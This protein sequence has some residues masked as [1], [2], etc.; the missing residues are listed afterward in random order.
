MLQNFTSVIIPSR[1]TPIG[2]LQRAVASIEKNDAPLE[3]IVVDDWSDTPIDL[4]T[5]PCSKPLTIARPLAHDGLYRA[6]LYA[7]DIAR[8]DTVTF[9]DADDTLS[10][11][12]IDHVLNA[13]T[14]EV[15]IVQ[16]KIVNRLTRFAIPLPHRGR[17]DT[18]RLLDSLLYDDSL[19]P[20]NA[21]AKLYRRQLLDRARFIDFNGSWGEDRVFNLS[22][23]PLSPRLAVCRDAI[24]NYYWS[25]GSTKGRWHSHLPDMKAV[26]AIKRAYCEEHGHDNLIP[27]VDSELVK[28]LEYEVRMMINEGRFSA[29]ALEDELAISPWI[30]MSPRPDATDIERRNRMSLKRALKARLKRYI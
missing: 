30:N 26:H 15:D 10:P 18:S 16:F 29:G 1:N 17:Y 28:F 22:L 12:A 27:L 7:L 20:I 5:L 9:V 25:T 24:Y 3:I 14:D 21:W 11:H 2:L 19:S 4:V 6:R 8:G 23:M 13:M